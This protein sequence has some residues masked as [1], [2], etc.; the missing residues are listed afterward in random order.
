MSKLSYRAGYVKSVQAS[1]DFGDWRYKIKFDGAPEEAKGTV[2]GDEQELDA[3]FVID[4][5]GFDPL[6]FSDILSPSL[7]KI[8]KW[9]DKPA[10]DDVKNGLMR[11]SAFHI[12]ALAG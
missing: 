2:W 7:S 4:A 1:H 11:T 10:L 3:D 8:I 9:R 12:Q 5:S 6:W